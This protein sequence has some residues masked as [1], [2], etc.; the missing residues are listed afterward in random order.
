MQQKHDDTIRHVIN[1]WEQICDVPIFK[2]ELAEQ[3][4]H[5]EQENQQPP[6]LPQQV[7][8]LQ[9]LDILCRSM[10]FWIGLLTIPERLNE[11][12]STSKLGYAIPFHM[13]FEDE[14]PDA[15]DR[16]KL[17]ELL[18]W[19]PQVVPQGTIDP[20][21]GL[22]YRKADLLI[23]RIGVW[24]GIAAG[25]GLATLIASTLIV[26]F[27]LPAQ[28]MPLKN[29][30]VGWVA[31]LIGIVV[32]MAVATTKRMREQGG[33]ATVLPINW[34]VL[35]IESQLGGILLK[36]LMALIGFTALVYSGIT[37]PNTF[38]FNALLVG[39]SLDSVVELVSGAMDQHA[40]AQQASLAKRLAPR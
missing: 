15:E 6:Q 32:H 20:T 29:A 33:A 36:L 19:S 14:M 13:V 40:A 24:L 9:Q 16:Q 35:M 22:V 26:W 23:E 30:L 25:I 34:V 27:P 37:E 11:W 2:D 28:G 4:A 8:Q 5:A 10:I 12:L 31:L 17:L 38:V 21:S 7:L 18:A 39:Y 1:D 3:A